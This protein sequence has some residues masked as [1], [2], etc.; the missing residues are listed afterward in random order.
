MKYICNTAELPAFSIQSPQL[1]AKLQRED[2]SLK[3][4]VEHLKLD[5]GLGARL[6]HLANS[7]FFGVCRQISSLNEAVIVLGLNQTRA[8]VQV[9][10]MRSTL[11]T[12]PWGTSQVQ[13]FWQRSLYIAACCQ[14]LANK[15]GVSE[16]EAFTVGIFHNLG[17]LLMVQN[18]ALKYKALVEMGAQGSA[19]AKLEMDLFHVDHGAMGAEQLQSLNFPDSLCNAIALQYYPS[20]DDGSNVLTSVLVTAQLIAELN[21]WVQLI[22]VCP[23]RTLNQ[24][25]LN[26]RTHPQV[27]EYITKVSTKWFE[28]AGAI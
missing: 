22:G 2:L 12:L 19:L 18:H 13:K 14:A 21:D 8:L 6:L 1:L 28:L 26:E 11:A 7:P 5:P 27:M 9:E 17:V 4:L 15:V 16:A 3:E 24:F 20:L 23:E 25:D 10:I